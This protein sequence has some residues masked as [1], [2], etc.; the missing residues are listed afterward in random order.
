[1]IRYLQNSIEN[2]RDIGGY[3]NNEGGIIKLGKLI[4]SNLPIN[5]SNKD[6][7]IINKMGINTI[8]DLRSYEE[9][10]SRK[11][12]FEG[13]KDFNI[14]HIGMNIG[15]D[16]PEEEEFVPKSYIEML[17]LQKEIKKIFEI[18]S[19]GDRII[20]FCN[21]GKDRTGVITA[22]ILKLLG[23]SEKDIIDDYMYT[24]VFMKEIL[25]KYANNN[26]KILNIITPKRIYMEKF[27]EEFENLYG[28]I[29]KYLSLIGIEENI[30]KNIKQK[31][32]G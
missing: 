19:K 26:T 2:M 24:K 8:I 31:F 7:S 23:V 6:I 20:Y 5:L 14:Y 17:T 3:K 10:K 15:K 29:E 30:I 9:I 18:L 12:I 21:A 27:L 4:R 13:N 16:I 22:L 11:S 32:I 28:S 1:M 25:K